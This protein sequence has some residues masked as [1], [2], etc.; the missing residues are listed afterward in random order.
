MGCHRFS[1]RLFTFHRSSMECRMIHTQSSARFLARWI[2]ER[3][4]LTDW[5]DQLTDDIKRYGATFTLDL[6][7][8][9]QA[10]RED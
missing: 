10:S 4:G 8:S 2:A 7:R 6:V 9:A 3:Y 5:I 1:F